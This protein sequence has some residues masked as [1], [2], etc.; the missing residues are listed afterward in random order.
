MKI[1]VIHD[2]YQNRPYSKQKDTKK[3]QMQ[4]FQSFSSNPLV[5]TG[6]WCH[7]QVLKETEP[8]VVMPPRGSVLQMDLFF[9]K[10]VFLSSEAKMKNEGLNSLNSC[11]IDH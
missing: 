2:F 6:N 5:T 1:Q 3:E 9:R 10:N 11:D 7:K 8:R 4:T